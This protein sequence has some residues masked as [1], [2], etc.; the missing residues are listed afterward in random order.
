MIPSYGSS[1]QLRVDMH[2]TA[3]RH[4]QDTLVQQTAE[5]ANQDHHSLVLH[6]KCG[7]EIPVTVNTM[8]VHEYTSKSCAT[9][10]G[11]R[12]LVAHT[13]EGVLP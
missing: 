4:I 12:S 8:S 2:C 3:D 7:S 11:P 10:F 1:F 9:A 5:A 6:Q 13:R